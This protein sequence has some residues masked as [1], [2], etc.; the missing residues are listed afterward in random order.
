MSAAGAVRGRVRGLRTELETPLYRNAY[1]LMLNTVVNSGFGL[2]YWIFAAHTYAPD[3]VG[4]GN[5]LVSLM[6]LVS[7]LTQFNFGQAL[8]RFL[9]RAGTSTAGPTRSRPGWPCWGPRW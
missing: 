7:V 6:M 9:P 4:R 5:A 3:E 2:L 1:A 8:I